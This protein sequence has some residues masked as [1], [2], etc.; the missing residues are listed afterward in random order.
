[1]VIDDLMEAVQTGAPDDLAALRAGIV[2]HK[3]LSPRGR[4][5]T[6]DVWVLGDNGESAE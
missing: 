5:G 2:P 3:G 4:D 1:V 6:I